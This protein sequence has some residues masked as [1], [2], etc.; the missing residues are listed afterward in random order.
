MKTI[1][2]DSAV[3]PE[4]TAA[5]RELLDKLYAVINGKDRPVLLGREG[6][7]LEFPEPVFHVLVEVV[8]RMRRGE[9]VTVLPTKEPLTTQAAANHLG[10]SRPYLVKLL[11]EGAIPHHMCGSHRRVYLRDLLA[12][13]KT[14]SAKRREHLDALTEKL[15]AEDSYDAHEDYTGEG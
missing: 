10:M 14:R 4:P 13:E 3:E 11:E 12:Y 8:R 1:D 6:A 15:A 2:P 5:D 7:H 9:S